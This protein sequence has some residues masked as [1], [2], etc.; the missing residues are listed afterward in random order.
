MQKKVEALKVE[1]GTP[2][3]SRAAFA[4]KKRSIE[5]HEEDPEDIEKKSNDYSD[6]L[7]LRTRRSWF[8]DKYGNYFKQILMYRPRREIDDKLNTIQ[9]LRTRRSDKRLST[10]WERLS[11]KI[12]MLKAEEDNQPQGE[13]T[14]SKKD[15]PNSWE[16]LQMLRTRKDQRDLAD[17]MMLRVR[18]EEDQS[19][20]DNMQMLRTRKDQGDFED[21]LDNLQ[22]LRVRKDADDESKWN[23]MQML[24]T[25]KSQGDLADKLMLRVRKDDQSRFDNM[26]MLRTRKAQGDLEDKLDNLQMLRVGKDNDDDSKWNRLQM[27]RARKASNTYT[28]MV[29]RSV[30][31]PKPEDSEE[32]DPR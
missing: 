16:N 4:R 21:K 23:S 6:N 32:A 9:M 2:E 15:Q 24:R 13:V 14:L 30:E 3:Q 10:N 20:F 7:M 25:R 19:Q 28:R 31:E 27:L 5:E 18:K 12:R 8:Q 11:N 22:M 29:R 1:N 26:Q 17:K